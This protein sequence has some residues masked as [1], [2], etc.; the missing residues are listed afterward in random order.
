MHIKDID[1]QL[2]KLVLNGFT[3]LEG[4]T[5]VPLSTLQI[6]E[7]DRLEGLDSKAM[8]I[9]YYG[10]NRTEYNRISSC[11]TS[12]EIWTRLEVTHEGTD[13][14]KETNIRTLTRKYETFKIDA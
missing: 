14:V 12:T 8:S 4:T 11:K 7:N 9:I 5:E 3:L 10:L 2:W 6:K 13:E 1:P